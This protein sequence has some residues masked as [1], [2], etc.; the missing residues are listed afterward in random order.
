MRLAL[1]CR[2]MIACAA[3]T[4]AQVTTS[5]LEGTVNDP[6]AAAIVGADVRI[7][8]IAT[9]QTFQAKSDERGY[10]TVPSMSTGTYRVS[11]SLQGFKTAVLEAVKIDA[12]VP[13]TANITLELGSL[14]ETVE[15][16]GGAEILQT[17]T[18][19]V[20]STMVGQQLHELPF[21]SR[22]ITELI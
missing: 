4:F 18:A 22:N 13:A 6:Q 3:L 20:T 7:L 9:G 12:G 21:T 15:V 8:N 10:W 2:L 19:T 16:K 11:V 14:A 5:R 17:S 1:R